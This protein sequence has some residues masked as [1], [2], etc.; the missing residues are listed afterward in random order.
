[1][2]HRVPAPLRARAPA[3]GSR[4]LARLIAAAGDGPLTRRMIED[5]E[6]VAPPV[7]IRRPVVAALAIVALLV[8]GLGAW[9]A[10][11]PLSSAAIAPGE[12][13]V[14]GQ[15]RAVQHL[16]GGIVREIRVTEGARV[17]AGA[18][19]FRLD[20]T[21]AQAQVDLL[22]SQLASALALE[23]RLA[24]EEEGRAAVTHRE[25]LRALVAARPALAEFVAAQDRAFAAGAAARAGEIAI[26]GERILQIGKELEGLEADLAALDLQIGIVREERADAEALLAT[27]NIAK[28][29]VLALR[30][31]EADVLGDRGRLVAT[32]AR[33]RQQVTEI[34]ERKLQ[35]RRDRLGAIAAERQAA[36]ERLHDIRQRRLAAEEV[37]GRLDILAPVGGTVLGLGVNTVG[38][39]I[40]PGQR[41]LEIVPRDLAY[42]VRARIR[43]A[44]IDVVRP[45]LPARVRLT[46]YSTRG[47]PPL[48]GT[49]S[50]VSA[51]RMTLPDT[52]E[53]F[54][55]AEIRIDPAALALLPEVAALP[56]MQAE[57][58][59]ETGVQ[60]FGDYLLAPLLD[61]MDRALRER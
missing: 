41:L 5:A 54:F 4:A 40:Q 28:P 3:T 31:A 35:V 6:I 15:R 37:L 47:T 2:T 57:V 20:R 1:M 61:G 60:T 10:L 13:Q 25:E 43:P 14:E 53:P 7:R 58:M 36:A 16:E 39:V 24:A 19:L 52:G 26:L 33:L 56:G 23:A 29:R 38:A 21:R 18:V 27:G 22:T 48:A 8:G 50:L 32:I 17:E 12:V 11:A 49:V 59:V 55:L 34:E 45:G 30:R 42:V 46:A 51:D 44:D 9:A